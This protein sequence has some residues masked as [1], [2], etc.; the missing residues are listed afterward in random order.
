MPDQ[1]R[2]HGLNNQFDSNNNPAQLIIATNGNEILA[3][4]WDQAAPLISCSTKDL[5]VGSAILSKLTR[6]CGWD[7]IQEISAGIARRSIFSDWKLPAEVLGEN[8]V[9]LAKAGQNSLYEELDPILR[10]YFNPKDREHEDEIIK[11]AYVSSDDI[12]RYERGFEDF[13]RSRIVPIS[14]ARGQEVVTGKKEAPDFSKRLD[15]LASANQPYMQLVIG[16]VGSG[17]TSFLK[18][19][20]N[21]IIDPTLKNRL[22][23]CRI[24]FNEASDDLQD[25]RNW[26]CKYFIEKIKDNFSD[27]IDTETEKGLLSVFSK[28]IKDLSGAY[29][30]LKKAGGS[31]YTERLAND[32][33]SWMANPET[34]AR[35]LARSISGDRRLV[36]IV[37]FDNVDRRERESQL[38]IFQT[39]QWFM[40]LTKSICIMTMRDETFELYKDEKPLDAFLKTSNFY[41]RPPRFVDMVSKRIALAIEHL[42]NIDDHVLTYDIEG[43]GRVSYPATSLGTYLTA[44][45]VDLF[46]KKRNITTIL[47]GLSGRNARKSLEMFSAV[48]TSA[49]FDTKNFTQSALSSGAHHIQETVLLRALM[50]TNYLYFKPAHGFVRN[51]YDPAMGSV[52]PGHFLRSE[53]LRYLI[54]NRKKQ[55]DTRFEGYFTTAHLIQYFSDRGFTPPDVEKSINSLISD[56]LAIAEN[57]TYAPV[58]AETAVR[59]TASGYVHLRILA[60]RIEYISSCALV[61]PVSYIALAEKLGKSWFIGDHYRDIRASAKRAVATDFIGYLQEHLDQRKSHQVGTSENERVGSYLIRQGRD[62]VTF[63]GDSGGSL[64]QP[65]GEEREFERLFTE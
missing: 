63:D 34:F 14:D 5:T 17:K 12:T 54:D 42:G 28:E 18:R 64:M 3:G 65:G 27:I 61:T 48:L 44:V 24:N 13:L 36:L 52:V 41:I 11:K 29:S 30:L 60:Q 37:A 26:V 10:V 1:I 56:D 43:F 32:L 38:K 25:I 51:L 22:V 33:L 15:A 4:F 39:G 59:V 58:K 23:Y 46:K 55:G 45:Y 21:Y 49:H 20:F 31:L 50:R 53:I 16:G 9:T 8:R 19:F 40:N 62:A 2:P 57:L 6:L 47:E 35:A 7:R